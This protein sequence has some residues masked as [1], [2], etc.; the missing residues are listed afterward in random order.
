MVGLAKF[1]Q[2]SGLPAVFA[3]HHALH[4][5]YIQASCICETVKDDFFNYAFTDISLHAHGEGQTKLCR[6]SNNCV[7]AAC[8]ADHRRSHNISTCCCC[9]TWSLTAAPC[10]GG[11]ACS[12]V[13]HSRAV[14]TPQKGLSEP[15]RPAPTVL[16]TLSFYIQIYMPASCTSLT[17]LLRVSTP[18]TS[19]PCQ[20]GGITVLCAMLLVPVLGASPALCSHAFMHDLAQWLKLCLE[21]A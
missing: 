12:F 20:Q 10:H 19:C 6:R 1:T 17:G 2:S 21:Q 14:G 13:S 5:R 3:L 11:S 7:T 8:T 15:R 18:D 9:I 16:F 4:P